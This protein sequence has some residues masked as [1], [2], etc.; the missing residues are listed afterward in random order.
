M[1]LLLIQILSK[2]NNNQKKITSKKKEED[3]DQI[4]ITTAT[5]MEMYLLRA[6]KRKIILW[7]APMQPLMSMAWSLDRKMTTR[8]MMIA[9]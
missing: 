8:T 5:M 7:G 2:L 6:M 9:I 3:A 1:N 4:L